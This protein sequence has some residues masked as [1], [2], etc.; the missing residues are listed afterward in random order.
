MKT[1]VYSPSSTLINWVIWACTFARKVSRNSQSETSLEYSDSQSI[2]LSS[3]DGFKD[4][5]KAKGTVVCLLETVHRWSISDFW[6]DDTLSFKEINI[7]SVHRVLFL[8][9]LN[10]IWIDF[11]YCASKEKRE[12]KTGQAKILS[13]F[14][15]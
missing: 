14:S 8:I 6:Q 13:R 10:Q 11:C 15:E 3:A 2:W 9:I 1:I 4:N 7:P 5:R 12:R